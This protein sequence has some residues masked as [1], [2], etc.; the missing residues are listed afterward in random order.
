MTID[1][2]ADIVRRWFE[3]AEQATGP[4]LPDGWFGGRRGESIFF[5]E[6]IETATDH[7]VLKLSEGTTLS[8]VELDRAIVK[9][10]ELVFQGFSEVIVRWKHYG[11]GANAPVYEKRYNCGEVRLVPPIGTTIKL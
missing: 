2:Q 7:L 8:F 9:N 6:D 5:L 4:L 11:G 3:Q 10:S 1:Q